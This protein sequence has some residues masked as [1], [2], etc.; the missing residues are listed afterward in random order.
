MI[1]FVLHL[2]PQSK[3]WLWL[4]WFIFYVFSPLKYWSDDCIRTNET[5]FF[6]VNFESVWCIYTPIKDCL[7]LFEHYVAP[8]MLTLQLWQ[9]RIRHF[10]E[11]HFSSIVFLR[12][13][14]SFKI[15][16]LLYYPIKNKLKATPLLRENTVL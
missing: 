8:W 11:P 3:G 9:F 2:L 12:N 4:Q 16:M 13:I 1:M 5:I 6:L 10:H 15:Q 7:P 14:F